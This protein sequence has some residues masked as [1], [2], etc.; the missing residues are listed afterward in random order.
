MTECT[1]EEED[2]TCASSGNS[3]YPDQCSSL[4]GWGASQ[5]PQAREV[6]GCGKSLCQLIRGPPLRCL[7]PGS[8][9]VVPRASGIP[10]HM[11]T[12]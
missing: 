3:K 7:C 1:D 12:R 8:Q 5:R 10:S 9:S 2:E 6:N 11:G 4:G